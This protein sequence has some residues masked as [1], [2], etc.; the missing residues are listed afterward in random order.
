M[1][2]EGEGEDRWPEG[3]SVQVNNEC[4]CSGDDFAFLKRRRVL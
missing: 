1:N 3:S 4:D 2:E